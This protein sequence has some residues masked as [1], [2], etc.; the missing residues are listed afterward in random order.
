MIEQEKK[1]S[2]GEENIS[3]EKKDNKLTDAAKQI[4]SELFEL[5]TH[6][7]VQNTKLSETLKQSFLAYPSSLLNQLGFLTEEPVFKVHEDQRCHWGYEVSMAKKVLD[8]LPW[9]K[10]FFKADDK[11]IAD[12]LFMI[13]ISDIGKAGPFEAKDGQ[14]EAV[15]RRIF[16][17]AI[18]RKRHQQWLLECDPAKFH[19]ELHESLAQISKKTPENGISDYDAI[20]KNGIFF[21]LPLEIYFYVL[22]QVASEEAGENEDLQRKSL[23]LFS[24]SSEE[25]EFL[26]NIG[27]DPKTTPM[28][29]FFTTS[30]IQF[31][32]FFLQRVGLLNKDQSSLVDMSL[33]HHFSQGITASL[34]DLNVVINDQDWIK[35]V[36]FLEI[37]DKFEAFLYRWRDQSLEEARKSAY[38]EIMFQLGKNYPKFPHL[39]DW[40]HEVFVG[41]ETNGILSR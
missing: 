34:V 26:V 23:E 7:D 4:R 38:N 10:E 28:R 1:V 39:K 2:V 33:S 19:E 21:M 22:Q 18:F 3:Q 36:A 24:L 30:H 20:F 17:Q 40:Y 41:M 25:R 35:K 13:F 5:L 14:P 6:P 29:Y 16:N 8:H 11:F 9:I 27:K 37:L 31:G 32:E 12:L 15:V